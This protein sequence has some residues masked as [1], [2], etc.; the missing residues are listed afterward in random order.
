LSRLKQASRYGSEERKRDIREQITANQPH[1]LPAGS[2]MDW[3]V[4]RPR[5]GS[6]FS[7]WSPALYPV[8]WYCVVLVAGH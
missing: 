3:A 7:F 4:I 8:A 5:D 2:R 1:H 6:P